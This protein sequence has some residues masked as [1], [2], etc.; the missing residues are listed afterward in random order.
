[1]EEDVRVHHRIEQQLKLYSDSL[2][3]K[4]EEL[5]NK[6]KALTSKDTVK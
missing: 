3:A 2:E 5:T 4:N 1:L 6:L